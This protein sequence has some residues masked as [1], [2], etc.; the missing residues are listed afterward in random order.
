MKNLIMALLFASLALV[1]C[2]DE[3]ASNTEAPAAQ[4]QMQEESMD[5]NA[6]EATESMEN[7]ESSEGAEAPEG[8]A[9]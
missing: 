5:S 6:G 8:D 4:E 9:N 2:R 1:G 7:T 3:K